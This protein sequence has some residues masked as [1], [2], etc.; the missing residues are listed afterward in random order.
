MRRLIWILMLLLPIA[1]RAD[2]TA[3]IPSAP[4][5]ALDTLT[6]F[7]GRIVRAIDLTDYRVTKEY[8]IRRE[9][10]TRLDAPLDLDT[11]R[12]DVVRL[13]NLSIFAEVRVSVAV[14]ATDGVRVTYGFREMPSLIPALAF[15]YTEENGFSVGPSISSLNLGGN[16]VSLSGRAYFGGTEQYWARG[17]WPWITGNHISFDLYAAHLTRQDVRN[18]FKELSD[19]L[20][21]RVGRYLGDRGRLSGRFSL[22]RMHS[23][24]PGITL[25]PDDLDKLFSLGFTAGW[26]TRDSWRAPR[27][28][29]QNELEL[30]KTGGFLGGNGDFQSMNLD[31]RHWQPVGRSQKLMLS[32]L[33]SRQSGTV[34]VDFP[35][36]LRYYI[37]GAN[38][39]RGYGVDDP[40]EAQA[41]RNQA[42]GTAEYS[43]SLFPVE[44]LDVLGWSFGIGLDATVF[45]DAGLAWNGSSELALDRTRTGI[46]AGLRLL[47]P[48]AEMLRFD[49]G[50]NGTD[51]VIFHFATGSKPVAQRARIR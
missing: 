14:D 10:R 29:W 27:R 47:I 15:L 32:A 12:A 4:E 42:I 46:G 6:V 33:L 30:V 16:A 49:L 2:E 34:G 26:D 43:F 1:A 40:A 38:S 3:G 41:G 45:G 21:A 51:K 9:I 7:S 22:L 44:R 5:P 50:W 18:E 28:G 13:E 20:T 17:I 31:L 8:V 19:E 37:G 39:V 25:S 48:G 35:S 24:V 23:D 11:L 36:Y